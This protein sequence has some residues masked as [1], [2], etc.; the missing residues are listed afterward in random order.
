MSVSQDKIG[1]KV[2]VFYGWIGLV[3]YLSFFEFLF[4]YLLIFKSELGSLLES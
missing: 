2:K 3:S 1:L 4:S